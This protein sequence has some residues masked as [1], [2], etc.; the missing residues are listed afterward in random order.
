[1]SHLLAGMLLGKKFGKFGGGSVETITIS[2]TVTDGVTPIADVTMTFGGRTT[3]TAA[4]GT[5]TLTV[6]VGQ[7]QNLTPTKTSYLFD[8]TY[9]ELTT[10]TI[11]GDIADQDFIPFL[12]LLYATFATAVPAPITSPLSVDIGSL[13]FLDAGNTMSISGGSLVINGTASGTNSGFIQNDAVARAAG[14]AFMFNFATI[15]NAG[16]GRGL[17][18]TSIASGGVYYAVYPQVSSQNIYNVGVLQY[19]APL[20]PPGTFTIVERATGAFAIVGSRLMYVW[21]YGTAAIKP[22]LWFAASQTPNMS[23]SELYTVDL[24]SMNADSKVYS[25]FDATPTANDTATQEADAILEFTWTPAANETFIWE[26]RKTDDDNTLKIICIQ[27]DSTITAY[28]ETAGADTPLTAVS[29]VQTWTVGTPYRIVIMLYG[30]GVGI[31]VANVVKYST[32]TTIQQTAT[33]MKVAGFATG[34]NWYAW[35]SNL[36]AL[37]PT[38]LVPN[39]PLRYYLVIGDSK[40]VNNVWET[41]F[42]SLVNTPAARWTRVATLAVAGRSVNVEKALIDAQL[43]ALPASPAP[44]FCC[45]NLGTNDVNG[46]APNDVY[47]GDANEDGAEWTAALQY[48]IDA[49]HTKWGSCAVY[50]MRPWKPDQGGVDYQTKL[51]VI[52]DTLIAAAITGRAW[53]HLGPDESVFL[54]NGDGGATY[55]APLPDG[56]HPNTAGYTLTANQWKT[57]LGM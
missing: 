49:V 47:Y 5:Y 50:I 51:T 16:L 43:A 44:E 40:S 32:T 1:M 7:T 33:G 24:V 21:E 46:D 28:R 12:P 26:F 19:Y 13:A 3:L 11:I 38:F 35:K 37:L 56:I 22:M 41:P 8:P 15:V 34:A 4:D 31:N 48:I 20:T 29:T 25:F 18:G 52:D 42:E 2:G 10:S 27:A 9:R 39:V 30:T 23:F 53:A 6:P 36:T 55:I 54:E 45:I 14:R 17:A 57:T